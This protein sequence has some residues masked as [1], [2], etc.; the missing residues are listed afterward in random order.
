MNNELYILDN[1]LILYLRPVYSLFDSERVSLFK[2]TTIIDF[3]RPNTLKT[4]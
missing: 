2:S 1:I 3:K 4:Y